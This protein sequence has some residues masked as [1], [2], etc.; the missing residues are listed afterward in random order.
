MMTLDLATELDEK[1]MDLGKFGCVAV[2]NSYV[3]N[4]DG[5]DV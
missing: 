4:A 5:P 3:F 2:V 1:Y